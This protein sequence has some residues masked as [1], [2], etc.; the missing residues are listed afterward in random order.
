[1]KDYNL[2]ELDGL[3]RAVS[4]IEARLRQSKEVRNWTSKLAAFLADVKVAPEAQ[5]ATLQFQARLWDEN[6]VSNVGQGNID[7]S[8]VLAD[9]G[10]RSWLAHASVQALPEG[11]EARV[12]TLTQLY[13]E[14]VRRCEGH[15]NRIP[16]LKIFRVLAALF[17][18]HLTTI[19]H[20]W[21]L[22]RLCRQ[23]GGPAGKD[24]VQ[25][26]VFV[27]KRLA[28]ALGPP[29]PSSDDEAWRM[30]LPWYLYAEL[31]AAD[32]GEER[33]K[34]APLVSGEEER[35]LPLPA[36]RRRRGLTAIQGGFPTV[37][38]ALEFAK[39]GA[40]REEFL[41]Y[42]RTTLPGLKDS[43]LRMVLNILRS[44]LGT[45][46]HTANGYELTER[47]HAVLE[48]GEPTELSDW[49]LTRI[50]GVDNVLVDLDEEPTAL[51][52]VIAKL[53]RINPGWTSTFAPTS[54]LNWLR[55]LGLI[56]RGVDAKLCL[57][58]A[59]RSWRSQ[60]HWT[61]EMLPPESGAIARPGEIGVDQIQVSLPDLNTICGAVAKAG[62]FPRPLIEQFHFALWGP[63]R[64]HFAILTG[65]SGS[66]KTLLAHAYASA[67][68]PGSDGDATHVLT[69]P[70][71]PGWYDTAPLLG[72][73]NP[74]QDNTYV[75]TGFLDLLLRASVDSSHAYTVILDEMNLSHPEQYFA[76]IL[77]AMETG[78]P[79][80]LHTEGESLDDVPA[81]VAYPSNLLIIGTVNMDETT[82]GL[83]DKVLD[84][85]FTLEFWDIDLAAYPRW[86]TRHIPEDQEANVRGILT[87]LGVALAP[88]R[89]HFGW[90]TVDDVLDYLAIAYASGA[91]TPFPDRLDQVIY[92]KVL[93]KLR[94]ANSRRFGKVLEDLKKV[95]EESHL[96]GS[97]RKVVSLEDDFRETGSARFWR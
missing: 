54:L 55:S 50:L 70:V 97:H 13:E 74:L 10:F 71:Q 29:G 3:R 79:I 43:S 58:E 89:L 34:E 15:T 37:L 35:L 60:I 22:L 30:E 66:G 92:A 88:M 72:Y 4:D 82:H 94:G 90:R 24:P 67:L 36:A 47:G 18:D 27:V 80:R 1:M 63:K 5:R 41:D 7:V 16:H 76:P 32:E 48:S 33:V 73:V 19:A 25:W 57:T 49:M 69:L 64:R 2:R 62:V 45:I 31:V 42:L 38:G 87:A 75:R 8:A 11:D 39:D 77:S 78:R 17:P 52:E 14:L 83:S 96:M 56:E 9:E 28:E 68:N 86:G 51:Q 21:K 81:M 40:T 93:P 91:S 23:M 12:V 85:A 26:H 84:R 53:Q 46:K 20:R 6:P 44:E 65:L 95:L 59:G 61:P